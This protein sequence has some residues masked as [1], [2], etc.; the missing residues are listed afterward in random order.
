MEKIILDTNI[1]IEILKSN[2]EI[3]KKLKAT[4]VAYAISSISAM[5]LFFGALNKN[6][7]AMLKKFVKSFEILH[8]DGSV[9]SVALELVAKYAKSHGLHIADALIAATAQNYKIKLYTLN[10]KDF[11]FIDE[12]ILL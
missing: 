10:T 11:R 12:L 2:E 5:E 3:L 7:L 9:S 6:E 4:D 8:I 1:L